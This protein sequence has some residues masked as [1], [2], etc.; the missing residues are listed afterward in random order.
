MIEARDE[1]GAAMVSTK[2]VTSGTELIHT[3]STLRDTP[4]TLPHEV[5]I[6]GFDFRSGR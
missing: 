1:A 3:V 5:G 2:H 4:V 6:G